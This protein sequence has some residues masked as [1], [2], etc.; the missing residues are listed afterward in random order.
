VH[1][2]STGLDGL[3]RALDGGFPAGSL[4]ALT[5]PPD[6]QSE[7]L[8]YEFAAANDARYLSTFRPADEVREVLDAT[9]SEASVRVEQTHAGSLL[10]SPAATLDDLDLDGTAVVVDTATELEQAGRDQYRR[11]LDVCKRRLR[12]TDSVALLHCLDVE[13]TP[14]R[15]GLT[16][17]RA[18][19]TLRLRFTGLPD[20][21]D[22]RLYV[23]KFRGGVAPPE[24]LAVRFGERAGVERRTGDEPA[25]DEA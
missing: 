11:A 13:P 16:L 14:M 5:A 19:V 6:S 17:G 9:L 10:E 1:R 23:T 7:L 12:A 25:R 2:L 4:V 20:R 3:D 22:P 24:G 8:C 15:R 18:D 21:L